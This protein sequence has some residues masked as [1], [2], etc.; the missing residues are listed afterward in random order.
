M[1]F[2]KDVKRYTDQYRKRLSFVAKTAALDV[3]NLARVPGPSV[4]H[5]TGGD[6]GRL[7]IDTSNLQKSM[8]ASLESM[9]RGPAMGNETK[10][11]D[12][13]TATIIRWRPGETKFWTGWTAEYAR[14]M[15]ARYGFMRHAVQRWD[16]I[17]RKAIADAKRK[18]L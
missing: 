3:V 18:K 9:P 12:D 17:V 6:G 10:A 14:N 1:S 8:V 7:P 16:E 13:V 2:S 15:E 4:A 5:P 11:G